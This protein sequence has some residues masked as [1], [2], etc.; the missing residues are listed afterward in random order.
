MSD[1]NCRH[2]S[3]NKF[4]SCPPRMADGRHF[5]DYRPNCDLNISLNKKTLNSNEMRNWLVRNATN[6]MNKNNHMAMN[7]NGCGDCKASNIGTMLPEQTL[8]SCD[9]R[10]CRYTVKDV[11][12]LGRGR[13]Y[14]ETPFDDD[15]VYGK[16]VR[17]SGGANCCA[18]AQ[19]TFNY[20]GD[21]ALPEGS[22]Y[23]ERDTVLGG[24]AMHGGDPEMYNI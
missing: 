9:N 12:G 18:R 2:A 3:D 24:Q 6:V 5:T 22:D 19:E 14:A 10:S 11:N 7:K 17:R 4:F 13:V 8:V 21:A 15:N 1:N 23:L 20:Y 16:R